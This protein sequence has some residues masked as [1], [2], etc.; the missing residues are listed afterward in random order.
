MIVLEGTVL[1]HWIRNNQDPAL[2][3]KRITQITAPGR[4]ATGPGCAIRGNYGGDGHHGNFE[5]VA[6]EGG[7][8]VH[9]WR[10]NAK[11]PQPWNP[12]GTLT[13]AAFIYRSIYNRNLATLQFQRQNMDP[14]TASPG[15]G[16]LGVCSVVDGLIAGGTQDNGVLYGLAGRQITPWYE[17]QGGDGFGSAFL[18]SSSPSLE[19]LESGKFLV[20]FNNDATAPTPGAAYWDSTGRRLAADEIQDDPHRKDI[21]PLTLA[22]PA[23]SPPPDPALGLKT[24][25]MEPVLAP[26]YVEDNKVLSRLQNQFLTAMAKTAA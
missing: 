6:I 3:W 12:G 11:E 2:P 13:T 24:P 14:G 10:D 26:Q 5:L 18:P 20:D 1:A 15:Y 25:R 23:Q 9:Y 19:Q 17:L 16:T 4:K 22:D 7:S 21:I 8:V